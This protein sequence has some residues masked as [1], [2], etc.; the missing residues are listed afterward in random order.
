MGLLVDDDSSEYT[1]KH[2][3]CISVEDLSYRVPNNGRTLA[4][5]LN[6]ALSAEVCLS[7]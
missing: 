6:L 2:G 3:D 5:N 1:Y 7:A 4:H